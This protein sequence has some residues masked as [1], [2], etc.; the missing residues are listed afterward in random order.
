MFISINLELWFPDFKN[1]NNF[2]WPFYLTKLFIISLKSHMW[3]F[4]V[5]IKYISKN[6][7]EGLCKTY[8]IWIPW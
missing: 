2:E 4:F 5:H 6:I 8:V 1:R 7:T 3:E